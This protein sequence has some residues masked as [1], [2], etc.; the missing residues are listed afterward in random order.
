M[1]AMNDRDANVGDDEI[2]GFRFGIVTSLFS[3]QIS[4]FLPSSTRCLFS[5]HAT[6][7]CL[8]AFIEEVVPIGAAQLAP[9]S[10]L[11]GALRGGFCLNRAKH[12]VYV[13]IKDVALYTRNL[14]S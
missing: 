9:L 7:P 2:K 1:L 11:P 13:Y 6:I 14:R 4:H 12:L 3:W 10:A 5:S 8:A